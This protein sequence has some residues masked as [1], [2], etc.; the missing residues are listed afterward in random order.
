[1]SAIMSELA[2]K[3]GGAMAA[4]AETATGQYAIFTN[5][6]NELKES[7]GAGLLPVIESLMPV[8]SAMADFAADNTTT[9]EILVGVVA[10]LSAGILVAN[11]AMKAY[12]AAQVVV[13]AATAAWTA[14]QWLLNA[15]LSAN[16]IGVVIVAVAALAAGIVI[17]YQKSETFRNIVTAAFGAVKTAVAAVTGAFESLLAGAKSAFDWVVDHWKVALFFF[18]PIGAAVGLIASNFGAIKSAADAAYDFIVKTW[19]VGSFAFGPIEAAISAIAAAFSS[20]TSAVQAAIGAV[21]SLIGW[22]G[23]IHVPSIHLPDL[24]PFSA[25][26]PALAGVSG[27]AAGAG[28]AAMPAAGGVTINVYGSLDPEGTARA[29]KRV[30]SDH[31]RRAGR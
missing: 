23:K 15:A 21:Q 25:P 4:Q 18:G 17:A 31:D 9:I 13:K 12:A 5:Q 24:N 11:A 8:L 10:A 1:M 14:A 28:A 22:L 6:M 29:I 20:I 16:P 27:R 7:L 2:D 19:K 26:M 30:L 3:T